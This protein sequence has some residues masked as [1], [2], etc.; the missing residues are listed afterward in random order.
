MAYVSFGE[1]GIERI[2][3]CNADRL[4]V[5][6]YHFSGE[7]LGGFVELVFREGKFQIVAGTNDSALTVMRDGDML[8][9]V[10]ARTP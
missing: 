7:C 8:P 2:A 9:V 5:G 1:Q 3:V 10:D 6:N 4:R